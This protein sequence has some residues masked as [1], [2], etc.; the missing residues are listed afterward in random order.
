MKTYAVSTICTVKSG[1]LTTVSGIV[2]A[3][4][5]EDAK[6]VFLYSL[7]NAH[8]ECNDI[9][10]IGVSVTILEITPEMLIAEPKSNVRNVSH[11]E[12]V[13]ANENET[14]R[15]A[16]KTAEA[17]LSDIGDAEREEG[18]DIE[19]CERR[20]AKAIPIVRAALE[21]NKL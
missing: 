4:N 9:I 10:A 17:A 18:D 5:Q 1:D 21:G 11:Y 2:S 3:D 8:Y 15:R 13:L 20:A 16:L 19:W 7:I 12:E 6:K 14:L